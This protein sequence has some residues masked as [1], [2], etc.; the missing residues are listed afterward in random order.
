[1]VHDDGHLSEIKRAFKVNIASLFKRNCLQAALLTYFFR[2]R[3]N[4]HYFSAWQTKQTELQ[5]V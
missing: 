3:I 5:T 4:K 2:Q 1:M